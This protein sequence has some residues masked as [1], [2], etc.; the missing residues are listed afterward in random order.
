MCRKL[1]SKDYVLLP[2]ASEIEKEMIRCKSNLN[3]DRYFSERGCLCHKQ[4]WIEPGHTAF[5]VFRGKLL[6][7]LYE[8]EV[9]L[10][11]QN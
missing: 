3:R 7:K 10:N 1:A 5:L 4:F 9:T 2:Q 8:N 11:K 6:N